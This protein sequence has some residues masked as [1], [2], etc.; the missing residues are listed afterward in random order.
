MLKIHG[1]PFSAH[2]RKVILAA[3]EKHIPHELHRVIP[4]TPPSGWRELKFSLRGRER[5]CEGKLQ[6][7]SAFVR[8]LSAQIPPFET[9][10]SE[11][12]AFIAPVTVE[13]RT[14]LQTE[15]HGLG[16]LPQRR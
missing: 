15:G 11:L 2:T 16:V 1:V 14:L 3:L 13:A 6:Q 12:A 4:L 7:W 5:S 8:D 9:V 10:I